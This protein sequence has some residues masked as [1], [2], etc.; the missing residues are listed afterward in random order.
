MWEICQILPQTPGNRCPKG[1]AL[2]CETLECGHTSSRA[3]SHPRTDGHRVRSHS[4]WELPLCHLLN[5][6]RSP[7]PA[8]EAGWPRPEQPA[9]AR[10]SRLGTRSYNNRRVLDD[11]KCCKE[12][13]ERRLPTPYSS[14]ELLWPVIWQYLRIYVMNVLDIKNRGVEAGKVTG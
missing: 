5:T 3:V 1:H 11:T 7:F 4:V 13:G 9:Q 10:C 2:C 6:H 12:W 14:T 8:Q